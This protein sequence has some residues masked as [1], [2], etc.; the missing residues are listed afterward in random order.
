MAQR[1]TPIPEE[2]EKADAAVPQT[3]M[4]MTVLVNGQLVCVTIT[5]GSAD[6]PHDGVCRCGAC[7]RARYPDEAIEF[8]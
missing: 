8:F 5:E 1:I 7:Q 4:P 3:S 2:P 6:T